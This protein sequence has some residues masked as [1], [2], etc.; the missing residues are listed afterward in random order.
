M[1]ANLNNLR[2]LTDDKGS[3]T[4]KGNGANP[5]AVKRDTPTSASKQQL[6]AA[7]RDAIKRLV[8]NGEANSSSR[9]AMRNVRMSELKSPKSA[10]QAG[11]DFLP[12]APHQN[13]RAQLLE[14]S[15]K[16]SRPRGKMTL[17]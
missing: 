3:Q 4:L 15:K 1:A 6:S 9:R 14:T 12:E 17:N 5:P 7:R 2:K 16:T 8:P 11:R 10:S 13:P